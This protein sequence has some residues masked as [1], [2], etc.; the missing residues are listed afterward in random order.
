MYRFQWVQFVSLPVTALFVLCSSYSYNAALA[1]VSDVRTL[2]VPAG[3]QIEA[4]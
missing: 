3:F 1:A 4:R 2:Q